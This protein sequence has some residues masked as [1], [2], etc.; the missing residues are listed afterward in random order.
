MDGV[1]KVLLIS[2]IYP[3][4]GGGGSPRLVRWTRA[5]KNA[6]F[7][8]VVLT[9][10]EVLDRTNDPGLLAEVDKIARIERTNSLD[11]KR[12]LFLAKKAISGTHPSS[13]KTAARDDSGA[14]TP[15]RW[16]F[17]QKLRNWLMLPDDLIGWM[18]FALLRAR[19]IIKEEKPA[20]VITS[21]W[22][23]SVQLTGLV[24]KKIYG[25][26]WLADFRDNWA[27]HPYYFFP[28]A[29][30]RRLSRVMEK[31]VVRNADLVT[32]AYGLEG[33][34]QTYPSQKNK[35]VR[36]TNGFNEADF[37]QV[38][39][40]ELNG[41]NL[42]HLGSFYGAHGP[43]HFFA[44]LEQLVRKNPDIRSELKAWVIGLFYN[45]HQELAQ[46]QGIQDLV[47]F[48][49]FIPH[50]EALDWMFAADVLLLFL[51]SQPKEAAVIPGKVFEYIRAPG[52]ILALIP[53]GET[54][55]ILRSAGGSIIVPG[56]QPDR[57]EAALLELYNL[58][59]QG[60]KPQRNK[61]Y[62]LSKSESELG[63]KMVEYITSLAG[64]PGK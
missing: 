4:A 12:L 63:K 22:P 15:G 20:L 60:R 62:V 53:E 18:P 14:K 24:L 42:L 30:H 64:P 5:I 32:L 29:F 36:L 25:L 27:R 47:E 33:A 52:W 40:A 26:P 13:E 7:Q 51:D 41:F 58:W 54:A 43:E 35:F 10:K 49:N 31:S 9:V 37:A 61:E 59:K 48:R 57:I 19:R 23:H 39:P 50:R 8:P 17:L 38:K 28:T 21:S 44:A 11:P 56:N 16:G 46:K 34:Q 45:E 3:P 6:G 55:E 1:R 2:Y